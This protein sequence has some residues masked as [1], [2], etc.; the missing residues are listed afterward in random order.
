MIKR[1]SIIAIALLLTGVIGSILTI[2]TQMK[3]AEI[4]EEKV[5]ET[6]DFSNIDI[7]SNNIAITIV[8]SEVKKAK[9]EL[10]SNN[11]NYEL[12]AEVEG[13]T[14]KITALMNRYKLF[15]F[16][17]FPQ[18]QSLTVFIPKETYENIQVKSNNGRLSIEE[19]KGNKIQF[20]TNNGSINVNNVNGENVVLETDNGSIKA[21]GIHANLVHANTRNGSI[22]L[23]QIE[24]EIVGESNNG[25]ISL[26]TEQLDQSMELRTNNGRI[27]IRSESKPENAMFDLKTHNGSVKVFGEKNWETVVGDG[28]IKIKA[29]S[30]NGSISI[31]H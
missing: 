4:L 21:K 13:D 26:K 22:K 18:E 29:A 27:E 16:D 30:Q 3:S 5:I 12:S 28:E 8:P 11:V 14:L 19:L 25:R 23:E 20:E 9:V 17:I 7:Y 10:F 1:L 2:D 6:T 24:A 15:T 31:S